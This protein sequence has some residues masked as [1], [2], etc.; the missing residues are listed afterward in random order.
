[1]IFLT[2]EMVKNYTEINTEIL[3]YWAGQNLLFYRKLKHDKV[4]IARIL[5][6]QMDLNNRIQE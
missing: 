4:E 6:T 3:G 5:H 1:M 2:L